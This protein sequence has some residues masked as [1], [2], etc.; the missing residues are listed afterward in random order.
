MEPLTFEAMEKAMRLA[1][2]LNALIVTRAGWLALSRA[3]YG[4]DV[5]FPS[6]AREWHGD[7]FL[8]E[9]PKEAK[10]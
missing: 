3:F 10:A 2:P 5:P 1:E 8:V 7:W 9:L 4:Y 6:D